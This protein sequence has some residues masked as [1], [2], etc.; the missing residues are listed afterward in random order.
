MYKGYM[1]FKFRQHRAGAVY[2]T[3]GIIF[4]ATI[5][6]LAYSEFD[7]A[8]M[9]GAAQGGQDFLRAM[10]GARGVLTWDIS[11]FMGMVWRHPLVLVLVIGSAISLG[12]DFAAGEIGDK[13]AD[14][15]FARPVT[16]TRLLYKHLGVASGLLLGMTA[17]FSLAVF[18]GANALGLEPPAFARF[19]LAGGQYFVFLWTVLLLSYLVGAVSLQGKSVLAI[20]GGVLSAMYAIELVGGLWATF[21]PLL[22]Y[23][24]FTYLTPA[25]ALMGDQAART[26]TLIML[27]VAAVALAVTHVLMRRR[28]L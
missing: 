24:L 7:L 8:E 22:P 9:I 17:V 27:G 1:A 21:E 19:A 11:A 5:M 10:A 2:V 16:R 15:V 20:V 13:T 6:L 26:D 18:T 28:D 3:I 23:S 4:F 14:L 25:G 12:G